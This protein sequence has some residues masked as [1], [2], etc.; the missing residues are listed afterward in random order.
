VAA[1]KDH[2]HHYWCGELHRLRALF[3]A[4]IGAEESQIEASFCANGQKSVS[5]AT[6]AEATYA[7]YRRQSERVRR[8]WSPTTSAVTT[9]SALPMGEGLGRGTREILS[10][11]VVR[12][13]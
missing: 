13:A 6:R 8:T 10:R 12:R 4:A 2:S 7:E 9:Y 11:N 1:I 5:L 3:L